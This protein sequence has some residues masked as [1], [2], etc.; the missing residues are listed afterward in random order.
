MKLSLRQVFTATTLVFCFIALSIPGANAAT[1]ASSNTDADAVCTQTVDV[2]TGVEVYRYDNNCVVIFKKVGITTW[3]VPAGVTKIAT[4]IIAGGG[5]G[6][7]DVSGGGGNSRNRTSTAAS[8]GSGGGGGY[9]NGTPTDGGAG[10]GSGVTLQGYA[11]GKIQ[12][13]NYQNVVTYR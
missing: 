9:G 4:L 6:G 3:T 5:G 11:G 7:Y 2:I 13:G 1:V 8:G 10:T 12:T